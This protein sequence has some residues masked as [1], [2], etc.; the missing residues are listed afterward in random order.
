ML[1]AHPNFWQKCRKIRIC[2]MEAKNVQLHKVTRFQANLD[3][4]FCFAL[5][6]LSGPL[7]KLAHTLSVGF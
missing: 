6:P 5:S 7:V 4:S 2:S 3:V 1:F